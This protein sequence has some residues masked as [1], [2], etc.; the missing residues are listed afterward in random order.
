MVEI[1]HS[2]K[3]R[4][5]LK[6]WNTVFGNAEAVVNLAGYALW[7]DTSQSAFLAYLTGTAIAAIVCNFWSTH[8]LSH[9]APSS[10]CASSS[11]VANAGA[12]TIFPPPMAFMRSLSGN[13]WIYIVVAALHELQGVVLGQFGILMIDAILS[14]E[15]KAWRVAFVGC[16]GA[17][18]G[19]VVFFLTWVAE[20]ATLYTVFLWTFRLK[21]AI[22]LCLA[23]IAAHFGISNA[24]AC[25]ALFL[26]EM[27]SAVI[28]GFSMVIVAGLVDELLARRRAAGADHPLAAYPEACGPALMMGACTVF[29]KPFNS[30]GTVLGASLLAGEDNSVIRI[31]SCMLLLVMPLAVGLVQWALWGLLFRPRNR[32]VPGETESMGGA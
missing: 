4:V 25:A 19:V 10:A 21:T 32:D 29:S 24:I 13:V 7:S 15:N 22:A 20:R 9:Y 17:A 3:E 1:A 11:E 30:L 2:E 31:R 18:G 16:L 28:S 27:S 6:R 26:G 23:L 14:D 5:G 8:R 12:N